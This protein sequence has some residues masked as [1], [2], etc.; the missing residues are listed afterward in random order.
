MKI[1]P[2]IYALL[3]Y[4]ILREQ[5]KNKQKQMF[6]GLVDLIRKNKD[7][8]K[9]DQIRRFLDEIITQKEG[10]I[11]IELETA[12]KTGSSLKEEIKKTFSQKLAINEAK[13]MVKEKINSKLIG[14]AR[15]NIK[16]DLWDF[17]WQTILK[18]M[19]KVVAG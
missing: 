9:L 1:S 13:M 14:G 17:S 16:S 10:L 7:Q 15:I 5:D 2:K 18:K 8:K 3:I 6:L 19:K 4:E 12:W 11:E